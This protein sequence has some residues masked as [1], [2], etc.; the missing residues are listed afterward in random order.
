M[1]APP[2]APRKFYLQYGYRNNTEG[3]PTEGYFIDD[4]PHSGCGIIE[5]RLFSDWQAA[6][7][8]FARA[9]PFLDI[10]Q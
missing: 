4:Q 1:E 9:H 8:A 6:R 10:A 7:R 5:A 2:N 3:W